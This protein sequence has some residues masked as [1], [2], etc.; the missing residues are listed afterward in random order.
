MEELCQQPCPK[1]VKAVLKLQAP[2]NEQ[3]LQSFM[4]TMNFM[5]TFIP[6]LAKETHLMRSLLKKQVSFAWSSDM[7]KEFENIKLAAS[8]SVSLTHFNPNKSATIETDGS[9]KGLVLY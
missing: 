8:N 2:I 3:E 7:Q 6:N 4:G 9:L 5:S 1:K